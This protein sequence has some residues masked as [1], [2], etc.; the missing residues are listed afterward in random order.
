MPPLMLDS[1][2]MCAAV[3]ENYLQS[4]QPAAA[5]FIPPTLNEWPRASP[6]HHTMRSATDHNAHRV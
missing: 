5:A 6:C 3:F 1:E 4:G 2:Q